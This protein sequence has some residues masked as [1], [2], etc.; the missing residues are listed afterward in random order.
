MS[1]GRASKGF[2]ESGVA[3][4][5]AEMFGPEQAG[6]SMGQPVVWLNLLCLD[7]PLVAVSWQM[8]FARSFGYPV[9]GGEMVA[10]FLTAW[11]IYL[12]DRFGDS[13]AVDPRGPASL[14]Q[15]FCS[16]HRRAWLAVIVIVAVA[17]VAVVA[18]Q[19][20][21][22][23]LLAGGSVGLF[24]VVYLVVNQARPSVLESSSGERTLRRFSFCRGHDGGLDAVPHDGGGSGVVSLRSSLH[25]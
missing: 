5:A 8:L 6:T 1:E 16:R 18:T 7:A 23:T 15:R 2:E 19:L 22:Q 24:A 11:L 17:D 13:L 12:A 10:L 14:R 25:A 9:A 20:E 21:R 4:E 3:A